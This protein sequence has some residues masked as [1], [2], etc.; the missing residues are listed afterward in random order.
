MPGSNSTLSTI[1]GQ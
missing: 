1:D